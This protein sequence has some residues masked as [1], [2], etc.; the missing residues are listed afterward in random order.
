ML[1]S[2]HSG[3]RTGEEQRIWIAPR[4][5]CTIDAGQRGHVSLANSKTLL[6]S[7]ALTPPDS[8][9]LRASRWKRVTAGARITPDRARSQMCTVTTCKMDAGLCFEMRVG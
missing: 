2:A 4:G 5:A 7:A 8:T 9:S 1:R 3:L 6:S